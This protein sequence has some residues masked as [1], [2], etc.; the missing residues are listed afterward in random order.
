MHTCLLCP[1]AVGRR[2]MQHREDA[3]VRHSSAGDQPTPPSPPQRALYIH[4]R[5]HPNRLPGFHRS[6]P[7]QPV[8]TGI[9]RCRTW[10][11]SH[12][13][14]DAGVIQCVPAA[15]SPRPAV[16]H[17]ATP[18]SA[19]GS[20]WKYFSL[21]CSGMDGE[22]GSDDEVIGEVDI[23]GA[24]YAHYCS[25]LLATAHQLLSCALSLPSRPT[26]LRLRIFLFTLS[27][28]ALSL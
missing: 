27:L 14:A 21:L 2:A 7:V 10:H 8:R 9:S 18:G 25:V 1:S 15:D 23:H 28:T 3:C 19:S 16:K 4:A 26:N 17:P 6:R 22:L 11:P 5:L 13:A 12:I 20:R 24:Q